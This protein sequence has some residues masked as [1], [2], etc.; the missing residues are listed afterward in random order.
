MQV[1]TEQAKS[2]YLLE[3]LSRQAAQSAER[4]ADLR[5]QHAIELQTVRG[6]VEALETRI[7]DMEQT[8]A[9]RTLFHE[10]EGDNV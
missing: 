5:V 4:I 7:L 6:Q 2:Q 9:E 1:T 3:E 10:L 8:Q